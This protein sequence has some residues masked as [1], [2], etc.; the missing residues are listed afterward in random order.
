MAEPPTVARPGLRGVIGK[1]MLCIEYDIDPEGRIALVALVNAVEQN[2]EDE[3]GSAWMAWRRQDFDD[4]G[5]GCVGVSP[6]DLTLLERTEDPTVV[7]AIVERIV[8]ADRAGKEE[9]AS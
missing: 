1:G 4:G 9:V 6:E 7:R 2:G 3:D 8:L 5:L